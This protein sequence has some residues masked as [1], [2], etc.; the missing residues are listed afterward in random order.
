MKV[1]K[2]SEFADMYVAAGFRWLSNESWIT[3]GVTPR[4][5]ATIWS[6]ELHRIIDKVKEIDCAA[7][8]RRD[9]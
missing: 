8:A 6:E 4:L 5:V 1:F 3:E 7:S 2:G 9:R